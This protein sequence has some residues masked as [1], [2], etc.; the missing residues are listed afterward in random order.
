M[1]TGDD[2]LIEETV[3]R[4]ELLRGRFLQ[5]LRDTVRLPDG[6][7]DT[8]EFIV[9]PGAVMVVPLLDD[10]RIV[11]E[12]Q[13]RH[14]MGRVMVEFP[15]G[16]LDAGEDTWTCGRR[17]LL[18]ETGYTAREWAKAG[19]LHPVISYSTEFIEIWFARGLALQ[20]RHLDAGEFLEVFSASVDELL[21]WCRDGTVTDA[22]TLS[23]AL[24]LQNWR[25]GAWDL[26][27]QANPDLG[28]AG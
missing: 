7:S 11:L 20:E 16:K 23:A 22:K 27:W 9:H 6:G 12:R 2:H 15:A 5:V 8:R 21:A 4:E 28:A 18:E 26:Q 19:V 3:Q 17:E 25:A 13:Y 14:P 24:W 1:T 10:G